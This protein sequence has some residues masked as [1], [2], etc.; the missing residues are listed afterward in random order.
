MEGENNFLKQ[1]TAQAEE[2]SKIID[3][4]LDDN[5]AKKALL[6]AAKLLEAKNAGEQEI[7]RLKQL[8]VEAE[9]SALKHMEAGIAALGGNEQ[10]FI[11]KV[12]MFKGLAVAPQLQA[13]VGVV[14]DY[15]EAMRLVQPYH[16]APEVE[17]DYAA[18]YAQSKLMQNMTGNI[19]ATMGYP[20]FKAWADKNQITFD[21]QLELDPTGVSKGI[22]QDYSLA[23]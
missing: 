22:Q 23:M 21:T 8:A 20:L 5:D 2:L 4:Y 7:A 19:D 18:V 14:A 13:A 12:K 9:K 10:A 11:D 1:I 6:E 15:K 17:R 16:L 3:H